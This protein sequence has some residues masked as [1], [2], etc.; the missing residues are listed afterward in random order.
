MK[1]LGIDETFFVK[2]LQTEHLG[3][4]LGHSNRAMN[5]HGTIRSITQLY[6]LCSEKLI[7]T[8]RE[9]FQKQHKNLLATFHVQ[10]LF[11]ST[12]KYFL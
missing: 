4:L 5:C 2:V 6:T 8:P 12:T 7:K 11:Q 9:N 1:L 10:I 3:P